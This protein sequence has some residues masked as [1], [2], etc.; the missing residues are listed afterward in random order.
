MRT[1]AGTLTLM[2]C[3]APL[4]IGQAESVNAIASI[5]SPQQGEKRGVLLDWKQLSIAERPT[6]RREVEADHEY[7]PDERFHTVSSFL[8]PANAVPASG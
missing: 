1:Q 8:E 7:L 5:G 3:D 2:D 6:L 4:E